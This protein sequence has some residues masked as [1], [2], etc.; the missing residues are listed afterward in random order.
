[1]KRKWSG[2]TF[3]NWKKKNAE[4][5]RLNTH[6]VRNGL[7][8]WSSGIADTW[9][10]GCREAKTKTRHLWFEL[11]RD[12]F[13]VSR[14]IIFQWLWCL[15]TCRVCGKM[16]G[17]NMELDRCSQQGSLDSSTSSLR[18]LG[19]GSFPTASTD[20]LATDTGRTHCRLHQ[21]EALF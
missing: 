18:G 7:K 9:P 1:M 19:S 15:L 14:L 16:S 5:N 4:K 8:S 20:S 17:S 2:S 10:D 11:D 21:S 6:E 13:C 12:Y 3:T